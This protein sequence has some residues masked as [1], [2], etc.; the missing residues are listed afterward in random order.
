MKLGSKTLTLNVNDEVYRY[1]TAATTIKLNGYADTVS[2]NSIELTGGSNEKAINALK[3]NLA[4][5][6]D[7]QQGILQISIKDKGSDQAGTKLEGSYKFTV[8]T[9]IN[10][11]D[12]STNLTVKI[13]DKPLAK[14]VKTVKK[15]SI[16]VLTRD[17][18]Y[19]T[20]NPKLSNLSGD[21]FRFELKGP[22]ADLFDAYMDENGNCIVKAKYDEYDEEGNLVNSYVYST[23][24]TYK[25]TPVYH[26]VAN[27]IY[28]VNGATQSFK[29]K[30]GKPQLTVSGNGTTLYAK[31]NSSITLFFDAMLKDQYV[32]IDKVELLNY[33][34]DLNWENYG[35]CGTLS[36]DEYMYQIT[37]AKGTYKLK[38]AV[39]YT[40]K[41]GNE[42]VAQTTYNV[43]VLRK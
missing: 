29:V 30:Q 41:A 37:K 31:R 13:V 42:K 24:T 7:K 17:T 33:N 28:T 11:A 39:T 27:G 32:S 8:S 4:Y 19:M 25:V 14:A 40:D 6:L 23:K 21:V 12:L 36:V 5:S 1:Q 38:F 35:N 22:D 9:K 43:T 15:G 10:G 16:D 34:A 20:M 3:N 2:Y 26:I 18:A